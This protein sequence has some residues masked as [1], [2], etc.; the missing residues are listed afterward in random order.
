MPISG[1]RSGAA[2]ATTTKTRQSVPLEIH[3]LPAARP[4]MGGEHLRQP[5]MQSTPLSAAH[6]APGLGHS[7]RHVVVRVSRGMFPTAAALHFMRVAGERP[8]LPAPPRTR[9]QRVHRPNSLAMLAS[10]GLQAPPL[11]G[12]WRLPR[13]VPQPPAG[14]MLPPVVH[15]LGRPEMV[16]RSIGPCDRRHLTM[17]PHTGRRRPSAL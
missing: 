7:Q 10:R 9:T 13:W 4:A 12:L 16:R 17:V 5:A 8:S 3:P 11:H 15:P 2:S 14:R 6:V 1:R